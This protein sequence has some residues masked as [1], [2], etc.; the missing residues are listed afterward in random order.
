MDTALGISG[1]MIENFEDADLVPS[2]S[3]TFSGGIPG[4]TYTDLPNLFNTASF[5]IIDGWTS[6]PNNFWDDSFALVNGGYGS[7]KAVRPFSEYTTFTFEAGASSVGVGLANF[8][9]LAV[10]PYNPFP[11]TNHEIL[12]NGISLGTL[13][14]LA[15]AN[16][17]AGINVRNAYI[18]IDATDGD[19]INAMTIRNIN[20][21][22]GD[23]LIFDHLAIQPIFQ[24]TPEPATMLLLGSGLL[25]LGIF[26]RK[27]RNRNA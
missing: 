27:F 9:S 10:N 20:T 25:G 11:I 1:F 7:N 24:T 14:S 2:L 18:R 15:G 26:G 8:Q 17:T 21:T 19:V 3:I 16:W 5:P 12:I 13:E 4:V 22:I 6:F 23:A